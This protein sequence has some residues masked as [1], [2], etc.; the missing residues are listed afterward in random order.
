VE[1]GI[2]IAEEKTITREEEVAGGKDPETETETGTEIGT[3]I[4]TGGETMMTGITGRRGRREFTRT[5][6]IEI[7]TIPPEGPNTLQ[8]RDGLEITTMIEITTGGEMRDRRGGGNTTERTTTNLLRDEENEKGGGVVP[9]L[10]LVLPRDKI[11]NLRNRRRMATLL[12]L[13]AIKQYR[14]PPLLYRT[15]VQR[16][17]T[18]Q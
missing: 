6:G 1:G 10:P 15:Q 7:L 14:V 5:K 3:E 8:V 13:Y 4:M 18:Q 2:E 16:Q 11:L 12:P 9:L 17:R